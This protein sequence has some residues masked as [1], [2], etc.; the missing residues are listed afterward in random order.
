MAQTVTL[1]CGNNQLPR[2]MIMRKEE[3]SIGKIPKK[4]SS[5]N[6]SLFYGLY[7]DISSQRGQKI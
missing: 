4:I 6:P 1:L 7:L 3:M 2:I 5:Q